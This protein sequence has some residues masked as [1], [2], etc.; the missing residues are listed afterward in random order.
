MNSNFQHEVIV[1]NLDLPFKLF[2]F[3]GEAGNYNRDKHWHNSIEIFAVWDGQ[4]EF[5]ISDKRRT[6]RAGEFVIVNT[7]EVHAISAVEANKTVVVQIPI[8][9]FKDFMTQD[10]F[11]W[12]SHGDRDT[13]HRVFVLLHE[14]KLKYDSNEDAAVLQ[15]MSMYYELL[16]LLVANYRKHDI[17]E[18]LLTN[19]KQLKKLRK[20]TSYIKQHYAEE[21]SLSS[22][23][24]EF[25]YAPTYLSRMF[26]KY[27]GINFKDYLASVRLERAVD[28]LERTNG[29]I[30]DVALNNGFPNAKAFTAT[31]KRRFGRNPSEKRQ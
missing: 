4:L 21:L 19:T 3:E 13:D 7:N 2:A 27:A 29:H 16:Y 22:V 20:I 18:T 26:Q 24:E 5:E 8:D 12:F 17:D 1:P 11:I 15:V 25:G 6:L 28:E 23:A 9:Q 30:V 10:N 31:Y 14:M